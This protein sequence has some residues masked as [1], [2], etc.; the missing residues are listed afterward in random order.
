MS[1]QSMTFRFAGLVNARTVE[2]PAL[3]SKHSRKVTEKE[4]D[5]EIKL[6][7]N[8][9]RQSKTLKTFDLLTY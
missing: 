9:K 5:T 4:E 2:D 1:V 3:I 7:R 6:L 8:A